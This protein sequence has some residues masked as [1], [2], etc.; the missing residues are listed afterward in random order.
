MAEWV[1]LCYTYSMKIGIDTFGC[2]HGQSGIGTYLMS[3]C[4]HLPDETA[5]SDGAQTMRFEL[6]GLEMDRYTYSAEKRINFAGVSIPGT[7][8]SERLWHLLRSASFIKKNQYDCVFFPAGSR[9]LSFAPTIPT[10]AAV[11]D[12]VS[13]RI[14]KHDN[15]WYGFR[16]KTALKRAAKI[17]AASQFVRK[18][19]ISLGIDSRKIEVVYNGIDHGQFFPRPAGDS[20]IVDIKPFAV[21]RPYLIYPS[22]ILGPEKKHI[23]LIEAF[24]LFKLNTGLPHRLVLAGNGGTGLASVKKA[25][26]SSRFSSEIFI[27]GHFPHAGLPKLYAAADA[28][29]FPASSEGAALP[30]IEA[31]A[32]GI[33][34]ACAKSGVLPEIAG[35]NALFFNADDTVDIAIA[36]QKIVS[37]EALRQNLSASGVEW[38]KRFSWEKTV[39]LTLEVIKSAAED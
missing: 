38:T 23:E 35:N 21:K 22:S 33:P 26:S 20:D 30:V 4:A 39:R 15:P 1:F 28:C 8:I 17:I 27:T 29:V 36:L 5:Q 13:S 37:D 14:K 3:L 32:S 12:V 11:H 24:N 6:F 34:C 9:V 25:A 10:V 2:G 16:I 18:D 31:L 7:P 19:L